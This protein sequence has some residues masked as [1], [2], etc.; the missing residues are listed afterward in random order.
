MRAH[1][2][3]DCPTCRAPSGKRCRTLR[4]GKS[5]DTHEP[6]YSKADW[7]QKELRRRER[8]EPASYWTGEEGGKG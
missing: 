3:V 4:S 5:T 7:F 8:G 1:E 6:R 2:L